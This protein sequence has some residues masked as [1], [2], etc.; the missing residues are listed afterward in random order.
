[1]FSRHGAPLVTKPDGGHAHGPKG[2]PASICGKQAARTAQ[3]MR[4]THCTLR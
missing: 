1:M 2:C 3:S 4:L